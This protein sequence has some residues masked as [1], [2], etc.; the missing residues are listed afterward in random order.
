MVPYAWISARPSSLLGKQSKSG[1]IRST[2][3]QYWLIIKKNGTNCVNFV[4]N[5]V[6]SGK[7]V[8]RS[9]KFLYVRKI[10]LPP[11]MVHGG[12]IALK[13]RTTSRFSSE[14]GSSVFVS[15]EI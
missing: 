6:I 14:L 9:K 11:K 7:F 2:V 13:A 3:R 8:L 15:F 5:F 10:F 12:T 1:N 4:G